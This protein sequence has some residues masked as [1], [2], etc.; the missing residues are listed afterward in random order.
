MKKIIGRILIITLI[1]LMIVSKA[2]GFKINGQYDVSSTENVEEIVKT[3]CSDEFRGRVVAT[4]ENLKAAEYIKDYF[5]KINLDIF[6]GDSFYNNTGLRYRGKEQYDINNIVGLIK[7]TNREN[8][9]FLTAHFDHIEDEN[10]VKLVGVIDN[11]SGVSVLLETANKLS[12]KCKKQPIENDIVIV[13][14]N[15]EETGLNGS[16]EFM[17]KYN[18]KYKN[19]YNI[20]IDCVGVKDCTELAMGNSD[21][22]SEELYSA[23]KEIFNEE[24]LAY[25]DNMYATKNGVVRGTSD[26]QIFRMY[27]HPSVIIGDDDIVDIVHTSDDNLDNIDYTDLEKLSQVLSKFIYENRYNFKTIKTGN[28]ISS[29]YCLNEYVSPMII[30]LQSSPCPKS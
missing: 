19:Y 4:D 13:A 14:Y 26:H 5:N 23:I 9:V 8:A 20:N 18:K 22:K 27:G 11:A 16:Q 29:L 30:H 10:G 17:K 28:E 3:L 12:E 1:S 21:V 6:E 2:Y 24:N 7:G 25:N 15:A